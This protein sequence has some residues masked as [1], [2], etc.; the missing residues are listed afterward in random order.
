MDYDKETIAKLFSN[1]Q[2]EATFEYLTDNVIWVTIG[3]N[4][5]TNKTALIE[6]CQ[7]I[8]AYFESLETEFV[9]NDIITSENTVVITG[10][11]KFI[12]NG[13]CVNIMSA[14]DIYKFNNDHKMQSITSYC[15]ST[16]PQSHKVN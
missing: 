15:I 3:E 14:C 9:T 7:K 5:I 2:F 10:T 1:G 8:T 12:K 13:A 6:H 11:A 4:T 16:S